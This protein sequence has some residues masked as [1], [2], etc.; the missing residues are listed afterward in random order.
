MLRPWLGGTAGSGT[1][2]TLKAIVQ[3][4]RLLFQDDD[5]AGTVEPTAYTGVA[6]SDIGLGGA[7]PQHHME[8]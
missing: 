8:A 6:A 2:A 3:H 5:V 7:L 1:S 4:L